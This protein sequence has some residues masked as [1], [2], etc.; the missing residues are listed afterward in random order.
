MDID[1]EM[2]REVIKKEEKKEKE[3]KEEKAEK[4]EKEEKNE[5]KE[6]EVCEKNAREE[7]L[8][9]YIVARWST[10]HIKLVCRFVFGR[11]ISS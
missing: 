9:R 6:K 7:V 11:S 5:K 8:A 10:P 1:L 2:K 3:D 4:E